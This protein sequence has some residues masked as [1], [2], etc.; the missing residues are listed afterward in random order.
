MLEWRI[1]TTRHADG[2]ST[3]DTQPV[4]LRAAINL[5][6]RGI[7]ISRDTIR[8]SAQRGSVDL[9]GLAAPGIRRPEPDLAGAVAAAGSGPPARSLVRSDR[10]NV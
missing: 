7:A 3:S 2:L 9:P 6:H 5:P 1:Q 4:P 8:G 10:P